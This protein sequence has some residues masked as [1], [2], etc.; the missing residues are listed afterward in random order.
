MAENLTNAIHDLERAIDK[1]DVDAPSFRESIAALLNT[2]N[3]NGANAT[4]LGGV[5]GYDILTKEEVR[6]AIDFDEYP[7]RNSDNAVYGGG[8]YDCFDILNN[9]LTTIIAGDEDGD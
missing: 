6:N 2:L 8:V 3:K 9:L 1:Q 5:D 7:V 4:S